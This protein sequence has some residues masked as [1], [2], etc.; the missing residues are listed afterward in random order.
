MRI[1]KLWLKDQEMHHCEGA[2]EWHEEFKFTLGSVEKWERALRGG[3][4]IIR[5]IRKKDYFAMGVMKWSKTARLEINL[6]KAS[7]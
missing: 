6:E 1:S 3:S 5:Y 4:T 7:E 2:S